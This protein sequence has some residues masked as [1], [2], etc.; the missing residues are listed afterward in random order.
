LR[1]EREKRHITLDAVSRSTKINFSMLQALEE[2]NTS[3]IGAEVYIKGFVRA[4]ARSIGIDEDEAVSDY[5][6]RSHRFFYDGSGEIAMAA[7]IRPRVEVETETSIEPPKAA[8]FILLLIPKR[9]REGLVGD[10]DEEFSTIVLPKCGQR[11]ACFWYWWQVGAILVPILWAQLKR[12]AG[13]ALLWK[14]VK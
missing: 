4:Y 14:M 13:L 7:E 3:T 11:K 6:E 5:L 10:L 8:K 12:L 9:Y 1:A 2:D